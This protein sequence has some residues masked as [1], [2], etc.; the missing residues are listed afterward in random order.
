MTSMDAVDAKGAFVRKVATYRDWI[1][2]DPSATYPAA[3]GR[4]LLVVSLA[5]PWARR[6]LTTLAAK[7][8][9]RDVVAVRVVDPLFQRTRPNDPSDEHTGWYFP[10]SFELCS[11]EPDAIFGAVTVR[12]LYDKEWAERTD[13]EKDGRSPTGVYSV[14]ILIDTVK[15]RIV[16]NESSEI[17]RMFNAE[18]ADELR[19]D[20]RAS[21]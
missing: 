10:S 18:Y 5:C 16:A 9:G 20:L 4:Y 15:R 7:G 11:Q 1:K 3:R 8:I 17:I 21:V 14:P 2:N 12:E 13:A 6:C 19:C